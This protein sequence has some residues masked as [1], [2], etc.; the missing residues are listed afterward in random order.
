MAV[1]EFTDDNFESEVMQS[2]QPVLVDFWAPYCMPCRALLPMI[3][4]LAADNDGSARIG[5]LNIQDNQA[6]AVKLSIQS[7]P[8][9][10]VFR[11][12]EI[13]ERVTGMPAKAALQE[14][15]DGAKAS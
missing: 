8:T 10:M 3:E 13:V 9:L 15:L 6:T 11:N 4:E 5:K 12:G 1:E 2:D 14:A 7:V